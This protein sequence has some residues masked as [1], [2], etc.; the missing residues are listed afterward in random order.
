MIVA[1]VF[2]GAYA[3]SGEVFDI[4]LALVCGLAGLAM[5]KGKLPHAATVLGFVL[6][7][8]MEANLRR[9][10]IISGGSYMKAFLNSGIS[11]VLIS[12]SVIS[13]LWA[14]LRPLYASM[15]TRNNVPA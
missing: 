7:V 15:K 9:A 12:I 2:T 4:G 1:L 11:T 10:L 14:L 8:I 6:G 5:R 13:V 3:Y